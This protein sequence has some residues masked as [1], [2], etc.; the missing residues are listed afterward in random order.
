MRRFFCCLVLLA[1]VCFVFAGQKTT[2]YDSLNV[3]VHWTFHGAHEFSGLAMAHDT[4][5]WTCYRGIDTLIKIDASNPSS[6][7]TEFYDIDTAL[8]VILG[9][10][11]D[12]MLIVFCNISGTRSLKTIN[13]HSSPP[14][15]VASYT[16]PHLSYMTLQTGSM[17]IDSYY[18]TM[19][20]ADV[21]DLAIFDL[22]DPTDIDTYA[23]GLED[24]LGYWYAIK[25][26]F[27]Y[28]I[29]ANYFAE[30]PPY[31]N[32]RYYYDLLDISDPYNSEY[33]STETL[34]T[35]ISESELPPIPSI[36]VD[37][38]LYVAANYEHA[39]YYLVDEYNISDPTHPVFVRAIDNS[40][41]YE[42]DKWCIAYQNGYLY[43]GM[44]IYDL[45]GDSLVG[46]ITGWPEWQEVNGRWI[47][48]AFEYS[49]AILEFFAY[50]S[51]T[52]VD[53][54]ESDQPALQ[55]EYQMQLQPNPTAQFTNLKLSSPFLGQVDIYNIRGQK[56]AQDI[57]VPFKSDYPIDL[58]DFAPGIYLVRAQIGNVTITKKLLVY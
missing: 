50:D 22:S 46:Y 23:T 21:G 20:Y 53:I 35:H 37:T 40:F 47:Y 25:D 58:S 52:R 15:V 11:D 8:I 57:I 49:F 5:L 38:F 29:Y 18:F 56:V 36:I 28:G 7:D 32:V 3:R 19:D 26:T 30:V 4:T 48:N 10:V 54:L 39:P 55:Y 31:Y 14:S 45:V 41:D 33:V 34:N 13:I 43:V 27:F 17:L 24:G 2:T 6:V 51:S 9:I 44:Y 12:S 1:V 16:S 42:M